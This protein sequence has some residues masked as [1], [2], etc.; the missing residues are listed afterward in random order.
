MQEFY[1]RAYRVEPN[2][3]VA[4]VRFANVAFRVFRASAGIW[5]RPWNTGGLAIGVSW[6]WVPDI[7]IYPS[8][9]RRQSKDRSPFPDPGS[10][11]DQYTVR[12]LRP[13]QP[14]TDCH[15]K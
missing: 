6:R 5:S 4:P 12:T 11:Q 8:L 14:P 7:T 9:G 10:D 15:P 13:G 2:S 3:G 1:R